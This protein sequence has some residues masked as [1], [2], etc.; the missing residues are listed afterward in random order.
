[1]NE[2]TWENLDTSERIEDELTR[3][4]LNDAPGEYGE[5]RRDI[6]LEQL[7][8]EAENLERI[9]LSEM[10]AFGWSRNENNSEMLRMGKK[11]ILTIE[12]NYER[13]ASS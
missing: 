12:N 5:E 9:N 2:D 10:M 3:G 11:R 8:N 7:E 13:M 4:Y 1:M 6:N